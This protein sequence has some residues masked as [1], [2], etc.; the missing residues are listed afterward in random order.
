M[1][2]MDNVVERD[3]KREAACFDGVLLA[4]LAYGALLMLHFQFLQSLMARP[5][6]GRVFWDS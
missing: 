4:T 3:S 2:A 6:R 1:S 5:K